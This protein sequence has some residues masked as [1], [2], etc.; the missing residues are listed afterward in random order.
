MLTVTFTSA[1]A[2]LRATTSVGDDVSVAGLIAQITLFTK[3]V[4]Q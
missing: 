2:L 4:Q 1:C 3:I